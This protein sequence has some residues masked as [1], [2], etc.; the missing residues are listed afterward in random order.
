LCC[1]FLP[2]ASASASAA[3]ART[4]HLHAPGVAY[5][6]CHCPYCAPPPLSLQVGPK[7]CMSSVLSRV[8]RY[9]YGVFNSCIL[10]CK[11]TLCLCHI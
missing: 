5:S 7:G 9:K 4:R 3:T 2:F 6:E 8:L 10:S 1:S 11:L